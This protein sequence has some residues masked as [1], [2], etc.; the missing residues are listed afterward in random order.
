MNM[1]HMSLFTSSL[2]VATGITQITGTCG[3]GRR[4]KAPDL[5]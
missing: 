2:M 3:Y 1:M 4:G 5:D